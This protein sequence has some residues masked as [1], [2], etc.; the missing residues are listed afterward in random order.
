MHKIALVC[1]AHRE[2]GL[3]N[4]GELLK[5]LRA[6]E[7]DAVFEEIR[8]SE[9]DFYYE[10]GSVEAH[11]ITRYR[12]FKL[13]QSV[14]VDRYDMPQNLVEIKRGLDFIFDFVAQ[15]SQEYKFLNAE[16]DNSVHRDGFSYLNSVAC[17]R[18]MARIA[19][20]EERVISGSGDQDLIRRLKW[21]RQ[22][23]QRREL[24]MLDNIYQY[25]REKVFETGVFLV[26][27]AHKTGIV[28]GIEKYVSTEADLIDW[29]LASD[30]QIP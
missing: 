21:W 1:S 12:D 11:A 16:N 14:P 4:A 15:T 2:N 22:F 5:I 24:E 30:G 17:E 13:F 28:K 8:L 6:I 7:P 29:N 26:G 9:F 18:M 23:A 27:A 3:C 19:E 10:H 20:I 25:C